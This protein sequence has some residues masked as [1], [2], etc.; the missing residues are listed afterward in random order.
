[1]KKF[2]YENLLQNQN[3]TARPNV[4]WVAD[5]THLEIKERKEVFIFI[6]IDIYSNQIVASVFRNKIITS[7]E[8]VKELN[9]AIEKRIPIK[10]RAAL[11]IHTDRGT[12][13]TSRTYND[14][15]NENEGFIIP[16]MSRAAMPKDNAVDERFMRTFK[17]HKIND[18]TFQEELIYQI[19]NNPKFKAYR[20]L[21]FQYTRSLNLKP[22]R[23]SKDKSPERYDLDVSTATMLMV[24]PKVF[25]G[26]FRA[27]F[28]SDYRR[29]EI[30]RYK[31]ETEGVISLLDEIAAKRAE[32]VEK[33][34]F[35]YY[36]DKILQFFELINFN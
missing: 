7:N 19:E 13:F 35:D 30:D 3:H 31:I 17:Q 18:K 25:K 11:I 22:N 26:I 6:C 10:P 2:Y 27:F 33:T 4:A 15:V 16:S 14:F 8:I 5:I 21:F 34:P 36:E 24:E 1:M 23:K 20:K 29:P 28:G 12:Q 9:K 32:V